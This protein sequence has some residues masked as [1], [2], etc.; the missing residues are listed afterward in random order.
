MPS[1]SYVALNKEGKRV[2]DTI[3]ATS[4]ETAKSSLRGVG[5]IILEI[6]ELS[7]FT[8]DIELP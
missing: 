5:Y 8:K 6:N 2:K 7:A 1:Y 4:M 3:E